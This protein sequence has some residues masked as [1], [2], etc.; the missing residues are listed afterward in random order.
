MEG[1]RATARCEEPG[2]HRRSIRQRESFFGKGKSG[3]P[4]PVPPLKKDYVRV[5]IYIETYIHIYIHIYSHIYIYI[6]FKK[7]CIH[8]IFIE[9]SFFQPTA[10]F[11]Y[12]IHRCTDTSQLFFL[13]RALDVSFWIEK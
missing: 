4:V 5:Y 2:S 13:E 1:Q 12:E 10:K 8:E 6:H 11:C 7:I 3:V 9:P